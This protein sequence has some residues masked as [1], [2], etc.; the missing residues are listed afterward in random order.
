M[1]GVMRMAKKREGRDAY[2]RLIVNG[3]HLEVADAEFDPSTGELKYV[4]IHGC[5]HK[6]AWFG[7]EFPPD[8]LKLCVRG[9]NNGNS[10]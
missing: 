10:D 5:D 4:L 8:Y 9:I 3:W 6:G 7:K 1:K 2:G